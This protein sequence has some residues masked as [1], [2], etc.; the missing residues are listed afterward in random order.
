LFIPA[1]SNKIS[2]SETP[3]EIWMKLKTSAIAILAAIPLMT[4]VAS[5]APTA[6]ELQ[7]RVYGSVFYE[8]YGTDSDKARSDA[9]KR[10]NSGDGLGLSVGYRL[11]Q[12]WGI[13]AEYVR[14]DLDTSPKTKNGV[15]GNRVGLDLLYHL[16][17]YGV[18]FVG[19]LKNY[20]T[21]KSA[22]AANLGFGTNLF[23]N[24]NLSVFIES[25]FYK[26]INESFLDKGAKFGVSYTFGSAPAAAPTAAPV[27]APAPVADADQDG[28]TDDKDQCANTPI[29]D[30]VDTVGCSI[31]TEKSAS[32]A[33]NAQFD[34][35]SAVVKDTYHADIEK[36]ADFLKRFPNTEVEIG[37][38]ASNVGTPAYNLA[39]SQRRADAVANVLVTSFGIDRSRVKAVGYGITKPKVSGR[40]KAANAANRRIE[41]TV[42]ASVKEAVQ[43]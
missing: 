13:R 43:R 11:N 36:L 14:Q 32:I 41:A 12:D 27:A 15:E 1:K 10:A 23:L 35:D 42:T 2:T 16:D 24:D 28:V 18:Y 38:H 19:G 30:K 6:A 4:T 7:D 3:K 25:N 37:G 29:T 5:A 9:W 26:G 8:K 40:S 20:T 33:L 21:G 22:S 34:N 17:T 31:F 39:L